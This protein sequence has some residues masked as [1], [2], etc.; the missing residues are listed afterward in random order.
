MESFKHLFHLPDEIT[1]L[2]C[3]YMAPLLQSVEEA[4]IEAVK[5]RRNPLA[6]SADDFFSDTESIRSEFGR[7]INAP[8]SRV[9]LVPSVSYG[10]ANVARNVQ[11]SRGENII[12]AAEQFPSNYY[13]WERLAK[14]HGLELRQI[15]PDPKAENR[16][17][18]WNERLLDA[19]DTN[20]CLVAVS[21]THWADGTLFRLQ[22]LRARTRDVG[23]L[24]VV[25]GTQSVG[26]LPFDVSVIQPDALVCA[27]YKWLM[28][29]Y[30]LGLAYYGPYFDN[31]TPVE[32]NWINRKNS[33][34]FKGLVNYQ[35]EYETGAIR[36]EV[37]EHSNFNLVPMLLKALRQVN[38]FTPQYIQSYTG[39]LIE[40]TIADLRDSGFRIAAA[41]QRGNHLFGIRM[42][43]NTDHEQLRKT[44]DNE[45][46]I[47]SWRGDSLR[48]SPNVYNT[49]A[50]LE[51]LT[52][53]LT[54][55]AKMG[56]L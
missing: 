50:D 49:Q 11:C 53:I 16:E 40:S 51:K 27:G 5:K 1:Y 45:K 48:I 25:D 46:V 54:E 4:G 10:M 2:N 52:T 42:R 23:A 37:G 15:S 39:Q 6:F 21:H 33:S 13:P 18:S 41:G 34:D 8:S 22:D 9:V 29:P 38:E 56:V 44:L 32:E 19:I 26:A 7:L 17:A 24:L 30:A 47:V 12:L 3:A 20:T 55:A 28:G 14:E 31:G 43:Q 36:F 35:S